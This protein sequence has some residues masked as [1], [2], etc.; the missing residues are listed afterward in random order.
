MVKLS[1][2]PVAARV[3]FGGVL[4]PMAIARSISLPPGFENCA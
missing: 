2:P 4:E 3:I 1:V